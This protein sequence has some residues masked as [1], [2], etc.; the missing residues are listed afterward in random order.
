[1]F[2]NFLTCLSCCRKKTVLPVPV[3]SNKKYN[4]IKSNIRNFE[5]LSSFDKEYIYN[6][7]TQ[8]QKSELI[9]LYDTCMKVLIKNVLYVLQPSNE[10]VIT[11]DFPN[12][13]T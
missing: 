7:T 10:N 4:E 2:Y 11:G 5:P 12:I 1:M 3:L 9:E 6:C 8:E 13:Y